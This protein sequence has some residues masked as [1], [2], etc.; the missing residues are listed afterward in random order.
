M[1][2]GRAKTSAHKNVRAARFTESITTNVMNS[3]M[4][5]T[6]DKPCRVSGVIT[7]MRTRIIS[8]HKMSLKSHDLFLKSMWTLHCV[9]FP[10]GTRSLVE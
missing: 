4:H 3:R 2:V 6:G 7:G 9:P 8:Q 1:T 5:D 10:F